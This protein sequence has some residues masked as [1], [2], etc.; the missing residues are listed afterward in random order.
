MPRNR[1]AD[2]YIGCMREYLDFETFFRSPRPNN[3]LVAPVGLCANAETDETSPVI[4]LPPAQIIERIVELVESEKLWGD[5]QT[6]PASLRLSFVAKTPF[7]RFRDDI[8]VR[9]LPGSEPSESRI[10]VYS[11]SRIGHS[12]L[13]A[14]AK[15]VRSLLAQLIAK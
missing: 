8:D 1:A 3:F 2:H 11:R 6:D 15:R 13:G 14:N 10:A 7:L 12:D 9:V 5:L 4:A